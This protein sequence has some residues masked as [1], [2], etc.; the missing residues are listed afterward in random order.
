MR[1]SK[2]LISVVVSLRIVSLFSG[3]CQ[4]GELE[5]QKNS[6]SVRLPGDQ[7]N[8]F[9][10]QEWERQTLDQEN[11]GS[12]LADSNV[13]YVSSILWTG[14]NDVQVVGDYAYCAFVN[15]F[16]ILDVSDPTN[17][18]FLSK[19]YLQGAGNG[20]FVQNNYVYLADGD[21]GLVI[22]DVDDPAHPDSV[23]GYNTPGSACGV[24][25]QDSLAYVADGYSGL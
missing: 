11:F 25:V 16:V 15:G 8:P 21:A 19:V 24:F 13:T 20:I 18:V 22:I 14:V 17:P 12:R 10:P 3:I 23:G 7:G 9:L 1:L 2:G 4:A 6:N 5:E